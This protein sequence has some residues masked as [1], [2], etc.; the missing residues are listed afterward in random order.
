M[1]TAFTVPEMTAAAERATGFTDWGGTTFR[2]EL[3]LLID[4]VRDT[5]PTAAGL[6]VFKDRLQE[7]LNNRLILMEDRKRYP[8]IPRQDIK[9]PLIVVGLPRSGTTI[10]HYLLTQD[11]VARSILEWQRTRPS[12]P[13]ED[14]ATDPRLE[15]AR[16]EHPDDPA[17]MKIH[18]HGQDLP[19]ECGPA[20]LNYE[21]LTLTYDCRW[22]A[23]RYRTR[24]LG[25]VTE[26]YRWHKLC[27]QHFQSRG[28]RT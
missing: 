28:S 5:K 11:P 20:L 7:T 19:V 3:A 26:A 18:I 25:S 23:P 21:F 4:D 9:A 15:Q 17:W 24:L 2:D 6:Q 12:P 22:R 14:A 10:L 1:D 27:L 13:P 8:E 16:A